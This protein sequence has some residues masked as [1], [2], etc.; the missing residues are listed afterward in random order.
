[1][2]RIIDR[3]WIMASR[4]PHG[5]RL[6]NL[7][8]IL[9]RALFALR[10]PDALGVWRRG[11]DYDQYQRLDRPWLKRLQIRTVID[12]GANVGQ[13]A[14]LIHAVLPDASI[15]SFE[16]LVE[17]HRELSGA[18]PGFDRFHAINCGIGDTTGEVDFWKSPHTPSSSFL[19][20]TP[21]HVA[22]YPDSRS[23]SLVRALVR[24]LDEVGRELDFREN[25]FVK[26]DVQGYEGPV[27][28]GG[29]DTLRRTAVVLMETSFATLYREQLL[30]ADLLG[31]MGA[32]GFTF[33][34]NMA[35]YDDPRS[36]CPLFADSFFI[37]RRYAERVVG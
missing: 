29:Q 35:Q 22:A 12:I 18:L 17:C 23:S 25:L 8:E 11:V 2:E 34:G 14:R 21:L 26:I 33:H 15:Y 13:F 7:R 4:L 24:P 16:P 32:L 30:F 5:G 20:M 28:R 1:M 19:R 6:V 31:Q 27:L 3:A 9:Y 10:H 37:N 36:G